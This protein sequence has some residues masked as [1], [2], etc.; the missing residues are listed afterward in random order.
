MNRREYLQSLLALGLLPFTDMSFLSEGIVQRTIPGTQEKLPVIGLGTWETFDVSAAQK[1]ILTELKET[2]KVLADK[3]GKV[4]DSSPMYGF[5]EKNVGTISTELGI[6]SQLF[7]ATKVWTRGREQGVAQMNQSLTLMGRKKIDLMQVHNLV[8]WQV[9]LKTLREWKEAGKIRYIGITHYQA[10][11]Y[12]EME[13]I[14]KQEKLDFIQ[15][16]YNL[17]DREAENRILPL[18][19]EKNLGV[20]INQPLG[21]GKLF[22][23]VKDKKIPAWA[24]D[25]DCHSWAQFF[26]KFIV[27]NPAVTCAIPGT[28]N[29]KH[30]LDNMMAAYGKLPDAKTREKMIQE[31]N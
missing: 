12:A 15:V 28:G 8:D 17:A 2:M 11:A 16:N 9:H 26:L 5:S 21:V 4:V 29:P 1:T 6:N 31:L 25:F 30:M 10:G 14:M 22:G 13:K 3:S 20:M 23:R 18:A 19:L 7:M 27:S 24:A